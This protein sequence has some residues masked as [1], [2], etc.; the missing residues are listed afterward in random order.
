MFQVSRFYPIL[1]VTEPFRMTT[2]DLRV[3]ELIVSKKLVSLGRWRL[4]G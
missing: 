4:I 1:L 3:R 2:V